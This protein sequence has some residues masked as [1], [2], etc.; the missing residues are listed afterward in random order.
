MS[1]IKTC[2]FCG[3]VLERNNT[4]RFPVYKVGT[5]ESKIEVACRRCY[6][7]ALAKEKCPCSKCLMG[8]SKNVG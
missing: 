4:V 5:E 8:V 7:Y 1:N 6:S 3:V 2:L